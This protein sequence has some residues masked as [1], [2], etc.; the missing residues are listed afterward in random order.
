MSDII[1]QEHQ[2]L[3]Q[4]LM[5]HVR[6]YYDLRLAQMIRTRPALR[7]QMD[8][9]TF[10]LMHNMSALLGGSKPFGGER[11]TVCWLIF[12]DDLVKRKALLTPTDQVTLFNEVI[13]KEDEKKA[14]TASLTAITSIRSLYSHID[15]S[16]DKII[17]TL[18]SFLWIDLPDVFDYSVVEVASGYIGQILKTRGVP[19]NLVP[20]INH[21]LRRGPADPV[22]LEDALLVYYHR[23]KR[24]TTAFLSRLADQKPYSI[25]IRREP[26]AQTHDEIHQL[27]MGCAQHLANAGNVQRAGAVAPEAA[28]AYARMMGVAP[29]QVTAERVVAFEGAQLAEKKKHLAERLAT[30][31]AGGTPTDLKTTQAAEAQRKLETLGQHLASAGVQLE[32]EPPKLREDR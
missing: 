9:L 17:E 4:T 25:L 10:Q 1:A 8:D 14:K 28:Q 5:R 29:E 32:K 18:Q 22:A 27:I 2:Y 12:G 3:H 11:Y 13:E 6:E 31:G 15:P 16:L 24:A 7:S 30:S 26:A 19:E 23:M 20:C 21:S